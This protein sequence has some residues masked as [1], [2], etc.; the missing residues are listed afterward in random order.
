MLR[1]L[2]RLVLAFIA[3]Y[4]SPAVAQDTCPPGIDCGSACGAAGYYWGQTTTRNRA[5][6]ERA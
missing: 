6:A 5:P 1:T 4:L 3:A 2:S